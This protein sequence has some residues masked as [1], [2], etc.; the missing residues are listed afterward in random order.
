MKINSS[1]VMIPTDSWCRG[2]MLRGNV[3][4]SNA[5]LRKLRSL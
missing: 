5:T 3:A 1:L 2:E 4:S